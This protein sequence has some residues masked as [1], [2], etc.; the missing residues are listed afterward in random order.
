MLDK[1]V[2]PATPPIFLRILTDFYAKSKNLGKNIPIFGTQFYS[3]SKTRK[4]EKTKTIN[5]DIKASESK[6][7][8]LFQSLCSLSENII[9]N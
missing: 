2:V 1:D 9:M 5:P 6:Q 3:K 8:L 7:H 4:K